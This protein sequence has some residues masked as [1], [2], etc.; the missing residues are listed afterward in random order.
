MK[1]LFIVFL[2]L[3][4]T[5]CASMKPKGMAFNKANDQ[6]NLASGSVCLMSIKTDNK[7]KPTW[8]PEVYSIAVISEATNK[9]IDIY[10]HS[11]SMGDLL[12]KGF[13]DIATL[14]HNTSS[15]EGLISFQLLPGSY[16]LT[17]IRGGCSRSIGIIA[18][19]AT[20]DFPF[21]IPFQTFD[22]E[23]VYL[24]RIEMT[25]RERVSEDEIRSGN[26][27]ATRL[28][29]KQSGFGTGTFDV[30][31]YDNFDQDIEDFKEKYFVLRSRE[32]NKR[33]LSQWQ[34]PNRD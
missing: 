26:N 15:W 12:K 6:P 2:V 24:G 28:P 29:Q 25:N 20:F 34:K 3:T 27:L 33:I 8:P 32:V 4:L 9:K 10:V 11:L 14:N 22:K 13:R 1:Y 7:F 16:R 19:M 18:A 23:Y 21:D 17:S 30:N 5:G 31:I